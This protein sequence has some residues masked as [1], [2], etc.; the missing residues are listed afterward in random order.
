MLGEPLESSPQ[1]KVKGKKVMSMFG[2]WGLKK[3]Y[4]NTFAPGTPLI[5]R[6]K[7][8][9]RN[10]APKAPHLKTLLAPSQTTCSFSW[11]SPSAGSPW[12]GRQAIGDNLQLGTGHWELDNASAEFLELGAKKAER[13]EGLEPVYPQKC[14]ALASL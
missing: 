1:V 14:A 11:T 12:W 7:V 4:E 2:G 5:I 9:N 6:G 10:G 13:P 3:K 8:S